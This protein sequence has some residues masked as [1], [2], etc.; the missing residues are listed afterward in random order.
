MRVNQGQS[1]GNHFF[2]GGSAYEQAAGGNEGI[3][4]PGVP[5]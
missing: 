5:H 3:P 1:E 2:F 4:F